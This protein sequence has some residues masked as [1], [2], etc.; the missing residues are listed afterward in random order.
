MQLWRRWRKAAYA[1]F[2][3]GHSAV[4][5]GKKRDKIA[6]EGTMMNYHGKKINLPDN[7]ELLP[8]EIRRQYPGMY[9]IYSEDEKRVIGVGKTEEEAFAQADASGVEGL[10]HYAFSSPPD[11]LIF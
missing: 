7:F 9:I 3:R 8:A 4:H 1:C 5:A 10:W 6:L 11:E 2:V